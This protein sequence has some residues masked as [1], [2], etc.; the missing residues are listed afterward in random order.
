M[1]IVHTTITSR[2]YVTFETKFNLDP[3]IFNTTND[4]VPQDTESN[5]ISQDTSEVRNNG[6]DE[7]AD[8]T[9]VD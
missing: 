3:V 4:T 8:T 5:T 1:H 2:K 9:I 6:T 7:E